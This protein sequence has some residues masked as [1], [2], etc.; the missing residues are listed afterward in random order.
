LVDVNLLLLLNELRREV[1]VV[2]GDTI[3]S[4]TYKDTVSQIN[5]FLVG[6]KN[7]EG[8]RREKGRSKLM[9]PEEVEKD[10]GESNECAH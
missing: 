10:K 6:G 7:G 1:M 4:L 2:G 9:S 8:W 3:P 5:Y